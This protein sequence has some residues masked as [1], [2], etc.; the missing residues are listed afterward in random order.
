M[1]LSTMT[2]EELQNKGST[3]D[4]EALKELGRRVL[5]FDFCLIEQS[6]LYCEH[7]SELQTLEEHLNAEIPPQCPKCSHWL[8]DN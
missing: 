4:E 6:R 5:D 7:E 2:I 3:G 1:S 8:T